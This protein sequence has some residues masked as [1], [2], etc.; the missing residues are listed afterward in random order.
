VIFLRVPKTAGTTLRRVIRRQY[1]PAAIFAIDAARVQESIEEF[2]RLPEV[3]KDR[4]RALVGLM[5]FGLHEFLPWPSTYITML[6]DPVDRV[7]SFYYYVRRSPHVG[8]HN[9]V[10][11]QDMS[12]EDFVCSG[13]STEIDNGQTRRLSGVTGVAGED[14]AIGFGECPIEILETARKNLLKHFTVVGLTERFDETI[15][16]LRRMFGWGAPPFYV[17]GKV[18]RNRRRRE[19]VSEDILAVIEKYNRLDIELYQYVQERF[20]EL[21]RQQNPSFAMELRIF[22]LLNKTYQGSLLKWAK[23]LYSFSRRLQLG[24]HAVARWF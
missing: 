3:Q 12:L 9:M 24:S 16:L 13:I 1:E 10:A 20:E 5:G 22:K 6:R 8:L 19:D 4:I 17:K 21:V 2:M 7:I 15:I 11:F 23:G 14:T 18:A